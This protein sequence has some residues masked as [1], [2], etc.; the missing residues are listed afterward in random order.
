[1]LNKKRPY[2]DKLENSLVGE[3]V[4]VCRRRRT[5]KHIL[6]NFI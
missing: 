1:M 5:N 3:L 4:L 2:S 6:L